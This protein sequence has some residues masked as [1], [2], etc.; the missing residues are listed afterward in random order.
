[1]AG[2]ALR[3]VNLPDVLPIRLRHADRSGRGSNLRGGD[4]TIGSGWSRSWGDL[5][6]PAPA[7]IFDNPL[8]VDAV[9]LNSGSG[10]NTFFVQST[11]GVA[12]LQVNALGGHDAFL[13]G[14]TSDT[15]DRMRPP[16]TP[17]RS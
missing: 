17:R 1:M 9:I 4:L 15:L 13:V 5:I 14:D 8:K 3:V 16:S 7:H 12:S 10:Q 6:G 2:C 11:A